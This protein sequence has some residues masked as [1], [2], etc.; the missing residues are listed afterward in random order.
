[1]TNISVTCLAFLKTKLK[2]FVAEVLALKDETDGG[3]SSE[4]LN[5]MMQLILD[6]RQNARETK[7]WTTSDKIRDSLSALK[8]QVND[9]KDGSGWSFQ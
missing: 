6:L 3:N 8:I 9:G 1:M 4:A 2:V 5:G 7:D